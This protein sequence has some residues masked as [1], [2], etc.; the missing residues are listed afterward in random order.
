[1][2][3]TLLKWESTVDPP[4]IQKQMQNNN[5]SLFQNSGVS[6]VL[7]IVDLKMAVAISF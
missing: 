5:P 2:N 1:M 4:L 6:S 3:S 7:Q